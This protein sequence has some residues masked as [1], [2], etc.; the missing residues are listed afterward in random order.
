MNHKMILRLICYILRVTVVAMLP[1]LLI[2]LFQQEWSAVWG[3]SAAIVIGAALSLTTFL[4]PPENREIGAQE[5]F[6]SV[7]LCWI[8]VS[9]VGALPFY[10]SRE[11]PSFVDCFFETV[12]GFT[13]T[14]A[15]ILSNVEGLSMGLLYWRSFTHWLGGMGVL[16]F[17]LAVVP[18]GKGKNSLLHV[19][20]AESPG[21]Q[22]DKL[23]PTLQKTA[24]I[25]Y[26]IYI[27]LTLIQV[28]LL[29]LGGMP[30][31][32]SFCTAFGTAGTG[33]FGVK[34]DSLA[35]YSPYL[36]TV[37]TVF[38]ALFGMNFSIFY[39]LLLRQ[40]SKALCNQELRLYLGVMLGSIALITWNIL[41]L[42]QG[43]VRDSLH[44]AAFQVSSIMTTTGFST[45]DFNLWPAFSKMLL[46][47]LM[48]FG[49]CA[50]STGGGIKAARVLL[51]FKASKRGVR[52]MLRP[53]SVAAVH[54]DDQVVSEDVI[55]N[56]Y[57]YFAIYVL[58]AI[59]SMLLISI[60]EY[61]VETNIT[62]VLACL[63]N[64]G[65]GLDMVGPA[66][67]YGHFS[68]FSKLV[69][70][71]NMLAGRLE[72]FPVLMLFVPVAWKKS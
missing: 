66:A 21:P 42:F 65:P 19:M 8:A 45:V 34:N 15:S 56:T 48:I 58:I 14:G 3:I 4:V 72:L 18:M 22:V 38:M 40:F 41:P 46:V 61:S 26:A 69:L 62:A 7:A 33:G 54:M 32:D 43:N 25:L 24:K 17:L 5:G 53:R 6:I 2:A 10:I 30:I 31:F 47:G 29:L 50:G 70:S 55:Q 36:Q 68:S 27:A 13:T 39:M 51:M 1:A 67:N 9:L 28:L 57:S 12:S 71:F 35:G 59:S 63:N 49:A 64:I 37:C 20:R 16:V 44:H 60:D 11:I 52:R 23:V